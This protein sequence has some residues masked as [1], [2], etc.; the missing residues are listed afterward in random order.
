MIF[1]LKKKAELLHPRIGIPLARVP[2]GLRLGRGYWTH[3]NRIAAYER[4]TPAAAEAW[5]I[6]RLRRL[7][8]EAVANVPFYREAFL[9]L[10]LMPEEIRTLADFRC[11]PIVTKEDFRSVPLNQRQHGKGLSVNTGG[12]SGEPLVFQVERS[13]FAREWAHM[14]RLWYARGYRKEHLKL[15]LRGKHFPRGRVL[16]YNAVH[17]ELVVNASIPMDEVLAAVLEWDFAPIRWIHGYPSLV[18]EFANVVAHG[19]SSQVERLRARLFGVLLGSE[20]PASVY[21]GAISKYL[22]VNVVSWYGHSEMAVLAGEEAEGLYRALP[23]YGFAEAVPTEREGHFRLIS[24]SFDNSIH[25]F[26]RYD[27]G[28]IISVASETHEGLLFGIL[29]GRVGDFVHDRFGRRHSLTAILFG[30]HHKAFADVA[31]VQLVELAPGRIRLLITPNHAAA[32][33]DAIKAGFDFSDL[34]IEWDVCLLTAPIR[35]PNGKI[36]LKVDLGAVL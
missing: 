11:L 32:D 35:R 30:R 15:T 33:P 7:V 8:A 18:S 26:I 27:T 12:T 34:A 2:F 5:T 24:T 17:N 29:D 25:P 10:G 13:A 31:H 22:S 28:D 16:A 19:P 20:Y 23:T 14:H 9:R 4:L 21:R 1:A 6:T 36:T 3:R